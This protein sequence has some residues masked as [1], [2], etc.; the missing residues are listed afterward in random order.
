[1]Q[2]LFES[3]LM[4]SQKWEYYFILRK[5]QHITHFDILQQLHAQGFNVDTDTCNHHF[6]EGISYINNDQLNLN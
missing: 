2:A 3:I 5:K 4:I 6:Y 1:M